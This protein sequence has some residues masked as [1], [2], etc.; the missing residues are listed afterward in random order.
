MSEKTYTVDDR[1]RRA[2]LEACDGLPTESLERGIVA[3]LFK[4]VAMMALLDK[5]GERTATDISHPI[6]FWEAHVRS[7][8]NELNDMVEPGSTSRKAN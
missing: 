4:A 2:A 7:L 1:R 3:A 6:H 5:M 8:I